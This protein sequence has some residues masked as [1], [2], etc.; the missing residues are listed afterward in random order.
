M[1][2]TLITVEEGAGRAAPG[3]GA[4]RAGG[5]DAR[6][7]WGAVDERRHRF[8]ECPLRRARGRLLGGSL[9]QRLDLF[10]R[11]EAVRAQ[12]RTDVGVLDIEPELVEGVRRCHSR[13]QPDRAA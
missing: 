9:L 6:S 12:Q 7:L 3:A 10:A 11:Q 2:L 8:G 1:E 4:E 13:I 5:D